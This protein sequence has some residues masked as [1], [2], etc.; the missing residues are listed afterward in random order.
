MAR[1]VQLI[2]NLDLGP[3]L[4]S[5]RAPV[6]VIT[7]DPGLERVVPVARTLEYLAIW[8]HARARTLAN[9]GHLGSITKPGEFAEL[10]G[11]FAR[12]HDGAG[13]VGPAAWPDQ[14]STATSRRRI[15]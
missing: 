14:V 15:G 10:L 2:A 5:V 7:G 12:Q 11:A 9:T 8:P 3:E 4:L 13:A 1:R 6:L